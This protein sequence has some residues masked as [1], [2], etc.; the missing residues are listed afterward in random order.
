M[1]AMRCADGLRVLAQPRRRAHRRWRAR[2]PYRRGLML[3]SPKRWIVQWLEELSYPE[4]RIVVDEVRRRLHHTRR[5]AGLLQ[6]PHRVPRIVPL[7]PEPDM[8]LR[9]CAPLRRQHILGRSPLAT[10][11]PAELFPGEQVAHADGNHSAAGRKHALQNRDRI[12][13]AP[14]A[15]SARPSAPQRLRAP[16]AAHRP[17]T[18]SH[19]HARRA[20]SSAHAAP[21]PRPQ[22][23]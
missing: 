7:Q 1:P 22:P 17:H 3:K 14:P 6:H 12:V 21:R 11:Q 8:R 19:R 16:S 10:D 4:L 9:C 15:S 18:C 23:P 2:Q 5:D 20:P 13:I